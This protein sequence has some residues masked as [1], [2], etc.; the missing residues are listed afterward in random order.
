MENVVPVLLGAGIN[1]LDQIAV[2]IIKI[3]AEDIRKAL[4]KIIPCNSRRGKCHIFYTGDALRN[5]NFRDVGQISEPANL[6]D[7]FLDL[8]R[9]DLTAEPDGALLRVGSDATPHGYLA[10]PLQV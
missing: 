9:P 4:G 8:D 10:R 2:P 5:D 1:D 3:P 6:C 7:A